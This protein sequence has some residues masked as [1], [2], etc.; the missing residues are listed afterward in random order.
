MYRNTLLFTYTRNGIDEWWNSCILIQLALYGY[1]TKHRKK[2]GNMNLSINIVALP[3]A[4][5]QYHYVIVVI[6]S[7]WES[8]IGMHVSKLV[9]TKKFS[10][11]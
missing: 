5:K 1:Y 6:T 10:Y 8:R 4:S 2:Y 9:A 7:K 3:M 11:I